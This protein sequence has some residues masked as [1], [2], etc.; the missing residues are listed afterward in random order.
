MFRKCTDECI[1]D[2]FVYIQIGHDICIYIYIYIYIY[3]CIYMYIFI[4]LYNVYIGYVHTNLCYRLS[5]ARADESKRVKC[6][7]SLL[8][9]I[10]FIYKKYYSIT[11][12][13]LDIIDE[14]RLCCV[15]LVYNIFCL[16]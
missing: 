1:C 12:C 5:D 2:I 13:N 11:C 14:V 7:A 15:R 8:S 10:I 9:R 16:F 6:R 3:I 4:S